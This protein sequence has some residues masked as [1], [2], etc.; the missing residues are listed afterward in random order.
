MLDYADLA[1]PGS[2][3]GSTSRAEVGIIRRSA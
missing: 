3:A 2:A 1:T